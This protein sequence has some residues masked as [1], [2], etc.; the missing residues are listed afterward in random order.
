MTNALP[1]PL[2]A[3][4]TDLRG[5]PYMPLFGDEL[6]SSDTWITLDEAGR[7]AALQLWWA[8]WRQLPAASLPDDDRILAHLAGYGNK[9]AGVRAWRRVRAKVLHGFVKCSDGRLY[10]RFLSGKA[11][12]VWQDR[13]AYRAKLEASR[14]RKRAQ[15]READ[16][17][18][19]SRGQGTEFGDVSAGHPEDNAA[20]SHACPE[21]KAP[22]TDPCP[23]DVPRNSL[24]SVRVSVRD[25]EELCCDDARARGG[26]HAEAW[27]EDRATEPIAT[28]PIATGPIADASSEPP[29]PKS[30]NPAVALIAAFDAGI[31]EIFGEQRR[32]P[33]PSQKDHAIA[34]KLH[35][36]GV[37][38]EIVRQVTITACQ[39]LHGRSHDPPKVLGYIQGVA[40]EYLKE[41]KSSL[42]EAQDGRNR[43]HHPRPSR[44]SGGGRSE[45]GG[46]AGAALRRAARQAAQA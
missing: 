27:A 8:A 11:N 17:V 12:E 31:V 9:P 16:G 24:L 18:T 13:Q 14:E 37:T 29:N 44:S 23:E 30:R 32:R 26:D 40:L 42:S 45:P 22:N 7:S 38:P 28:G 34:Q 39:R 41:L 21:D 36:A 35:D 43:T 33:F 19:P 25:T 3:P 46:I 20:L 6:F 2:T 10:H 1:D 5:M 4:E 15:R